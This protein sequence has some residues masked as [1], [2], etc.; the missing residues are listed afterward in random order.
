[1]GGLSLVTK[2]F[3]SKPCE[4]IDTTTGILF[5]GGIIEKEMEKPK[6]IVKKVTV[7][8]GKSIAKELIK[9]TEVKIIE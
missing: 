4:L 2:G 7:D 5:G 9:V 8:G 3:L 6:I 1:M